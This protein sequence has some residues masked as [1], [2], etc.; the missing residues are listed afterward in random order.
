MSI[1][2]KFCKVCGR[3]LIVKVVRTID[4]TYYDE[5]T[6]KKVDVPPTL[7]YSWKCPKYHWWNSHA[8]FSNEPV[9]IQPDVF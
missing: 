9:E 5:Q 6:G 2:P 8:N 1:A 7:Y 3:A 4:N